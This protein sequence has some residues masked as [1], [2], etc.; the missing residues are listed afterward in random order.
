MPERVE[1]EFLRTELHTGLTT[2]RIAA[3]ATRAEKKQRNRVMARKAYD[4][5]L[6]FMG[7]SEISDDEAAAL[8]DELEELRSALRELGEDV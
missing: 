3:T 8:K 1:F 5:A 7:K 2:A 4:T 6:H